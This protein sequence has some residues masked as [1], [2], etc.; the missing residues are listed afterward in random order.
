MTF[1]YPG[2]LWAMTVLAIPVIVHLFNFRKTQKIY[3]SNTRF[4]KQ[5]QEATSAKR[6]LK[7]YLILAS[8]LL[9]LFFLVLV[10]AQPI[11]PARDQ[12]QAGENVVLYLDNSP[13]MSAPVAGNQRAIDA[14]L[15]IA[16]NIVENFPPNTRYRLVT[17]DFAP[18]SNSLKT[19]SEIIDLLSQV[20]VGGKS[21]S[22]QEV[23][24]KI[25]RLG[26]EQEVF[27][28]SDFQRSTI[29]S[30]V[31]S[32]SLK[33]WH[34]IPLRTLASSNI[35]ADTAY[36]DKPFA[37]GGE[38]NTLTVQFY[39]DGV[40]PRDQFTARL[41]LDGLQ[42][43]TASVALP[44]NSLGEVSFDLPTGLRGPH[45][46]MVS[47]TDTPVM[48][49]N[50]F[51]VVINFSDRVRVVEIKPDTKTTVVEKVF[52]NKAIF[53][54][55][56]IAS[57]NIDYSLL[58]SADLIILNEL[59]S[60]DNALLQTMQSYLALGGSILLVPSAEP[61]LESYRKL[62]PS[63][64]PSQQ[65][66]PLALAR[67]DFANPFFANV[68][69]EKSAQ[70][71]MPEVR[72][73]LT[74]GIDRQAIL[75]QSDD[76]PYLSVFKSSGTIYVAGSPFQPA[77]GSFFNNALFV[78]VMYRIAA[79]S[80]KNQQPVYY[81]VSQ[82]QITLKSDS[83]SIEGLVTLSGDQELTPAQRMANGEVMLD[84]GGLDIQHGHYS[85]VAGSDSLAFLAFNQSKAESRLVALSN[86]EAL[87]LL[88]ARATIYAVD[89]GSEASIGAT[90][91]EN[92]QGTPLWRYALLLA[93]LFVLVE[94]VLLRF[95][96]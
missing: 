2:F 47:F 68:F 13:S 96:K 5:V 67:P 48:F 6:R 50:E 32:D 94:V 84:L 52:G 33:H 9:F 12:L 57:K 10:F 28:I 43:G 8:R 66:K 25:T 1:L 38:R 29:G 75:K 42:A 87:S 90:I 39:N 63:V 35:F 80:R 30:K 79:F 92:Y 83:T 51:Y 15:S 93:I 36:L 61:S 41:I 91:R 24:D 78:P 73:S 72:N 53:D 4:I 46:A 60:I 20:R 19:K 74:W 56:S 37:I 62:V 81:L 31:S 69:Q 18:F 7:H 70:L 44:G 77:F 49:D 95:W 59:S 27:W 23:N 85:V 11:I 71:A 89:T 3:F 26:R 16:R 21:R 58:T 40:E 82:R 54:F 45:K 14:G 17:N 55:L 88:G 76:T 86:D 65:E 34:L 64:V 22:A